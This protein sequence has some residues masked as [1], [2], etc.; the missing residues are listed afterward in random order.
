MNFFQF[1]LQRLSAFLGSFNQS[2]STQSVSTS[3]VSTSSFATTED[4]VVQGVLP[5]GG[6]FGLF[7]QW[8][9]GST[10]QVISVNGNSVE[11]NQIITLPSGAT[12]SLHSLTGAFIYN[13]NSAIDAQPGAPVIET[14]TY[15]YKNFLGLPITLNAQVVVFDAP[16]SGNGGNPTDPDVIPQF[17]QFNDE[18]DLNEVTADNIAELGIDAY[19]A[20]L[21]GDD[22]VVLPGIAAALTDAGFYDAVFSGGSGNDSLVIDGTVGLTLNQVIQVVGNSGDD[23]LIIEPT[24]IAGRTIGKLTLDGGTGN[25]Q[26]TFENIT[27]ATELSIVESSVLADADILQIL[28]PSGQ[29]LQVAD[30]MFNL[31]LG[32]DT[33]LIDGDLINSEITDL[34]GASFVTITGNISGDNFPDTSITTGTQN[35]TITVSGTVT[36]TSITT[37]EGNDNVSISDTMNDSLVNVQDGDNTVTTSSLTNASIIAFGNG[38]NTI[39]VNGNLI[40]STISR[41]SS[42]LTAT[43]DDSITVTGSTENSLINGGV[44]NNTITLSNSVIDSTIQT[45]G[46]GNQSLTISGNLI[47]NT[48][49]SLILFQSEGNHQIDVSGSI[50]GADNTNLVTVSSDSPGTTTLSVGSEI[51]FTRVFLGD[52][53]DS[54]SAVII[55][56]STIDMGMGENNQINIVDPIFPGNGA[57]MSSTIL[58]GNNPDPFNTE[59]SQL[60]VLAPNISNT[61]F[62][63]QNTVGGNQLTLEGVLVD[64]STFNGSDSQ[65]FIGFALSDTLTQSTIDISGAGNDTVSFNDTPVD[66][67][68]LMVG[69][70]NDLISGNSLL[71]NGTISIAGDPGV[72]S[73]VTFSI[74]VVSS[75]ITIEESVKDTDVLTFQGLFGGTLTGSGGLDQ[76]NIV[77]AISSDGTS[78]TAIDLQSGD[79]LLTGT[80]TQPA[81]IN[82]VINM[83]IDNDTISGFSTVDSNS[84]LYLG[85]G[86][87]TLLMLDPLGWFDNSLVDGGDGDDTIEIA[88]GDGS[89]VIDGA[90][91]DTVTIVK[92]SITIDSGNDGFADSF[93]FEPT[94]PGAPDFTQGLHTINGFESGSDV[95]DLTAFNT[96][97]A[98]SDIVFDGNDTTIAVTSIYSVTV[99]GV[100]LNSGSIGTDILL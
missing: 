15:S 5:T 88:N 42:A 22:T 99:T 51:Q 12:L 41:L 24:D 68:I 3:S 73:N 39:Q 1:F 57:I 45:T 53:D 91:N 79:D 78:G 76:V 55:S 21:A 87:D 83:G 65:D 9:F 4:S 25:D 23:R 10:R 59:V 60:T 20:A 93:V 38:A 16:D 19:Q 33:Y 85:E 14:F 6:S 63:L 54:V 40:D 36:G 69:N 11:D 66:Q 32:D 49:T 2:V 98:P 82:S 18:L 48:S 58:F 50:I 86:N 28:S 43:G 72:D 44:G 71:Q 13:P 62:E 61:T 90:G 17:T 27:S 97:L 74:D 75:T 92:G 95:I 26:Y 37:G 96:T 34:D 100:E 56:E 80:G 30:S 84:Q 94:D 29:S 8:L 67:L 70:G 7:S 47:A 31:G 77:N 81:I 64:G 46:I 35:D 52:D 89:T